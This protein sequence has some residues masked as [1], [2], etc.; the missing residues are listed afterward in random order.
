MTHENFSWFMKNEIALLAVILVLIVPVIAVQAET[1]AYRLGFFK[2]SSD[3]ENEL[4]YHD[5]CDIVNNIDFC[6]EY[7]SGYKDGY[8]ICPTTDGEWKP[9][10]L[11]LRSDCHLDALQRSQTYNSG[12]THGCQDAGIADPADRHINQPE[13]G[14]SLNSDEF[15]RGYNDGF[16]TCSGSND[17]SDLEDENDTF[18]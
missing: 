16:G 1:D 13:T 2:G 17:N 6:T 8:N 3:Q 11:A 18:G 4:P 9:Y 14:P 5:K 15:M 12:Y 7:K 10:L